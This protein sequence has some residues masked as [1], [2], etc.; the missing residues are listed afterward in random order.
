VMVGVFMWL[1]IYE[2]LVRY[3]HLARLPEWGGI[4][5]IVLAGI[6]IFTNL[7]VVLLP[8]D[9]LWKVSSATSERILLIA[10]FVVGLLTASVSVG[11]LVY[12]AIHLDGMGDTTWLLPPLWTIGCVELFLGIICASLPALRPMFSDY[13]A[14]KFYRVNNSDGIN[15]ENTLKSANDYGLPAESK[16]DVSNNGREP[17]SVIN[18]SRGGRNLTGDVDKGIEAHTY[19]AFHTTE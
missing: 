8:L 17:W 13:R 19:D 11:R 15:E 5:S 7:A 14:R 3:M 16:T 12:S 18:I 10:F 6:N 4:V 1:A 2:V 9:L